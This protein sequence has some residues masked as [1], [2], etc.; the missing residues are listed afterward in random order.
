M[1]IQRRF[2]TRVFTPVRRSPVS[3]RA[4]SDAE[5]RATAA[6]GR[7]SSIAHF[8]ASSRNCGEKFLFAPGNRLP[9]QVNQFYLV[10]CPENS[11]RIMVSAPAGFLCR[12]LKF[13]IEVSTGRR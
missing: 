6:I 7:D 5:S 8:T 9:F 2:V 11:W 1:D 4:V 10:N 13:R 12:P 3:E